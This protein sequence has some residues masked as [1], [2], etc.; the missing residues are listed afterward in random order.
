[1][2]IFM[3]VDTQKLP[4]GA[5]GRVVVVVVVLVVDG[6]FLEL[7]AAELPPAFSTD[8]VKHFECFFPVGMLPLFPVIF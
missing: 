3:A 7:F 4:V 2:F 8:P 6:Q 5:V 1:M